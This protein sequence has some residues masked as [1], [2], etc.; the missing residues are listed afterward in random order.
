MRYITMIENL[1]GIHETVTY[2]KNTHLKLYENR[3][4]ENYPKHWH[5]PIEIIMPTINGYTAILGNDRIELNIDDILFI[6]PG[7]IHALE[8]PKDGQRII[9]QADISMLREIQGIDSILGLISPASLITPETA[10]EI[11]P[12]MKQILLEICNEY[13]N[14]HSLSNAAIYA[15]LLSMFVLIGKNY[16]SELTRSAAGNQ[17]Q[18]E[19]TE[20]F[21]AICNYIDDHC[22]EDL[23]LDEI[24]KKAG[25]SKY[26]FSRLFKQFSNVTFYKYLNQRRIA[27]AEMLLADPSISI[28]EVAL[29]SGFSSISAFIRMFKLIKQCTPTEFRNLYLSMN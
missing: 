19:Y 29:R 12:Q 1:K 21:L 18:K 14:M 15:N 6:C 20:N 25:F 23:T 17:K 10:P 13:K 9:F 5:T 2:T 22:T 3:E 7:V 28:T 4:S 24:A 11:H 26:H 8:S 27:Y 16:T